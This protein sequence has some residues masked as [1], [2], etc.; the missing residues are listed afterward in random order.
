M[1]QNLLIYIVYKSGPTVTVPQSDH[2]H[3]ARC[4]KTPVGGNI[5]ER[6]RSKEYRKGKEL[7]YYYEQTNLADSTNTINCSCYVTSF[8]AVT[9]TFFT[10]IYS[11]KER[12]LF[13]FLIF[14][15]TVVPAVIVAI[16]AGIAPEAYKGRK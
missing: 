2:S 10:V 9:P 7:I 11:H 15:L 8:A 14:F 3:T 16:T 1:P 13:F 6:K 4:R 5:V 12:F